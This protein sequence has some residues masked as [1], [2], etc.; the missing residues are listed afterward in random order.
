MKGCL[1]VVMQQCAEGTS[2]IIPCSGMKC[3]FEHA[4]CLQ[5]VASKGNSGNLTA[6]AHSAARCASSADFCF[7]P[8]VQGQAFC[9]SVFDHWQIVPG[10]PLD[11]TV[12]L[13]PLEPAPAKDLAREFMV[14]TRR[15]KVCFAFPLCSIAMCT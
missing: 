8:C 2:T 15:R 3:I 9:L 12:T 5:L 13:R 10:D 4:S 7:S 1:A 11:R 14:K 6:S